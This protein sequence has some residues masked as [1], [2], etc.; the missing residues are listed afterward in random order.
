MADARMADAR[1]ADAA[2][3]TD[4][5]VMKGLAGATAGLAA[6][7]AYDAVLAAGKVKDASA[8]DKA[9][10]VSIGISLGTSKSSSTTDRDSYSAFDST[11]SA[12]KDLT[13]VAQ[14]AGKDS[15][16]TVTGANLSAGSNVVLK[17]EGDIV[18]QAARNA[19]EQK[20]DSKSSSASIGIGYST[21]GQQNGFTLERGASVGR[22]NANGRNLGV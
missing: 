9:G 17:A 19:F 13:I 22:G 3:K 8:L 5:N 7:N 21:G 12:G 18:L 15:D 6:V 20:T 4:S 2:R 10:G 1:T 11:V 14:G 16:I